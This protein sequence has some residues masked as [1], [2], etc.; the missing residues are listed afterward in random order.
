[1]DTTTLTAAKLLT[2]SS[3]ASPNTTGIVGSTF[4]TIGALL[5]SS[6]Y[7]NQGDGSAVSVNNAYFAPGSDSSAK[8]WAVSV[9][10]NYAGKLNPNAW[11]ATNSVDG[12]VHSFFDI[13]RGTSPLGLATVL[14]GT[15][16][17]VFNVDGNGNAAL[18][19]AAAAAVPEPSTYAMLLA[20]LMMVGRIMRRRTS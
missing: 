20:G 7:G 4:G 2:T 14:D 1:M 18:Y 6:W 8:N 5:D 17:F 3:V 9:G 13:I 19:T 11:I 16:G 15:N 10:S 12:N